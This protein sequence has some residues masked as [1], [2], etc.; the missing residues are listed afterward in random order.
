MGRLGSVRDARFVYFTDVKAR[1]DSVRHVGPALGYALPAHP[2]R[3]GGDRP[4][5]RRRHADADRLAAAI[6]ARD[7]S[8]GTGT[9]IP[10]VEVA[11][12]IHV[13]RDERAVGA[14]GPRRDA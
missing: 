8:E 11:A 9:G 7:A 3:R 1:L 5:G 12:G 13:D 14:P 2:H 10:E 4:I 6:A